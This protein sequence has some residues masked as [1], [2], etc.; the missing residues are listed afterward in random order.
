M[1][2]E[3]GKIFEC[4]LI[5]NFAGITFSTV[6]AAAPGM[7]LAAWDFTHL[8]AQ[9]EIQTQKLLVRNVIWIHEILFRFFGY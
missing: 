2:C 7:W 1:K 8:S 3:L 4:K 5:L 9:P 6:L